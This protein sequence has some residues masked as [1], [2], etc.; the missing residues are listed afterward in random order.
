M[1]ERRPTDTDDTEGHGFRG[2]APDAIEADDTEGSGRRIPPAPAEAVSSPASW[3]SGLQSEL[4]FAPLV[5]YGKVCD[6]P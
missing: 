4:R 1:N 6:R 2:P 5:P 3:S